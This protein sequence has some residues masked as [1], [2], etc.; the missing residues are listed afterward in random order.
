MTQIVSSGMGKKPSSLSIGP[1]SPTGEKSCLGCLGLWTVETWPSNSPAVLHFS[2]LWF[3]FPPSLFKII[4]KSVV[5]E[6]KD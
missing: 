1:S 2:H 6:D 5:V 4:K 3:F